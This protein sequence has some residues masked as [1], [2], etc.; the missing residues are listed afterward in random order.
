M[1]RRPSAAI[2]AAP[3][4]TL[5]DWIASDDGDTPGLAPPA[6]SPQVRALHARIVPDP[7][8][9]QGA[10]DGRLV[11]PAGMRIAPLG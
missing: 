1:S 2:A 3:R 5:L 7:Q 6:C 4:K 11:P 8:S 9:S 10:G